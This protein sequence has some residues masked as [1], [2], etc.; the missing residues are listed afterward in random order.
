MFP[1]LPTRAM[2]PLFSVSEEDP[3]ANTPCFIITTQTKMG[4]TNENACLNFS[5]DL[6]I[7][8][9]LLFLVQNPM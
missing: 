6:D 1:L 4:I 9:L 2:S 8:T 3:P 5:W 7:N